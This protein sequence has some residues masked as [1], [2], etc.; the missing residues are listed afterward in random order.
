M[1]NDSSSTRFTIYVT[2]AN[3]VKI[4][5]YE[6]KKQ[7]GFTDYWNTNFDPFTCSSN[8]E[9]HEYTV[10]YISE[11]IFRFETEDRYLTTSHFSSFKVYSVLKSAFS[12][13]DEY[14]NWEI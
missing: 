6:N 1:Y 11:N 13:S 4:F 3:K 2:G 12:S 5:S 10:S 7:C 14:R 8:S 9:G